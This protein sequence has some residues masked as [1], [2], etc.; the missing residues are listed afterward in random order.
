[1]AL[2]IKTYKLSEGKNKFHLPESA[3]IKN[4]VYSR[5][6]ILLVVLEKVKNPKLIDDEMHERYFSV[7]STGEE[8]VQDMGIDWKYINT[9]V[10]N[11]KTLHIFECV[12]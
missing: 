7:V 6:D 5:C 3:E 1:M 12:S 11:E 8:I 10:S 9:V 2:V 4:V